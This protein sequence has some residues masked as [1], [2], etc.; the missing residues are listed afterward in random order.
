MKTIEIET[1]NNYPIIAT[2]YNDKQEHPVL[3]VASATGVKQSFYRKFSKFISENNITVIT[4]DYQGIGLSL[5]RKIKEQQNNV[6]D[7]GSVDLENV[8]KYAKEKYP[9]SKIS[10]LGHSIGGQLIGVAKSSPKVH[11]I[12][13]VSAQ[14]GYWKFWKGF[15]RLKMW[16]N[17]H[18][19]FPLFIRIFG[20]MP[21]K[22]LSGMEN[23]PKNVAKQ[24]SNWG[25]KRDYLFSEIP[26]NL[27]YFNQIKSKITAISIEN[28][29][30]APKEAVDWLTQKFENA[31]IK[32]IHLEPKKYDT[33]N[34]G[35]FGIFKEKFKNNLWKLLLD[36]IKE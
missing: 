15:E 25:R 30:F 26:P 13:L 29:S 33:K 20:Y 17:W 18:V 36:E 27:L 8:I 21:S 28:D 3:V 7:W 12:I 9:N 2:I 14:S 31:E 35:H 32:R 16:M 5:K 1:D 23:L 4:F 22:K 24:L 11:K 19:L 34:I 6:Q 10:V